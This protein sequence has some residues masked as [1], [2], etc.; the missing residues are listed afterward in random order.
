M[1]EKKEVKALEYKDLCRCTC[2]S[3][4]LAIESLLGI[5]SEVSC[6]ECGKKGKRQASQ[7]EAI[8]EWNKEYKNPY[9][10]EDYKQKIS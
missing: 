6:N 7:H 2:G 9:L 1:V 10:P 8:V 4:Y 3:K 5:W